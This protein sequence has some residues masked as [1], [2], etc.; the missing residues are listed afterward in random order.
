MVWQHISACPLCTLC[1]QLITNKKP[2]IAPRHLATGSCPNI[3][4]AQEV[5]DMLAAAKMD[6]ICMLDV[7]G[8]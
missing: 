6:N 3:V 7:R 4:S 1:R 5:A 8:R 2:S